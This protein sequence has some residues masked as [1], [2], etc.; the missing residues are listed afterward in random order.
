MSGNRTRAIGP[1]GTF[2]RLA[3]GV[4]FLGPF[5]IISSVPS[6]ADL[7]V[8][9]VAIPAALAS[10]QI[11]HARIVGRRLEATGPLAIVAMAVVAVLAFSFNATRPIAAT[12]VG[13]SMLLA[14][15]RG[16]A[17]CEATAISNWLLRRDDQI[18]CVFLAPFDAVDEA[19][20][21]AA[22]ESR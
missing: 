6:I 19:R 11:A 3:L 12:F 9:L 15:L 8:G 7:A 17:G 1:V 5:L 4:F 18:G 20:Q 21:P 2:G 16:Y 14:A 10:V 13:A 22:G